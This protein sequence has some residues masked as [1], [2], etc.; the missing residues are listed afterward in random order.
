[1]FALSNQQRAQQCRLYTFAP[2]YAPV[3]IGSQVEPDGN[4]HD[5][6]VHLPPC[7]LDKLGV[8]LLEDNLRFLGRLRRGFDGRGVE[9]EVSLGGHGGSD[10]HLA[11]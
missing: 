9:R 3:N 10:S 8:E 2:R 11:H 5:V 4:R 6:P 1:M 7:L